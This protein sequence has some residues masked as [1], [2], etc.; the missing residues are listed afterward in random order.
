[1][2]HIARPQGAPAMPAKLAEGEGAFAAQVV[3]HLQPATQ[4][5][6]TA[7]PGAG[8]GAQA[9]DRPGL[10]QQ[11][12]VHWHGSIIQPQ[13]DFSTGHCDHRRAIEAQQRP[14]HGDFQRRSPLVVAQ[15]AIAQ[16]Q[17][18]AVHRP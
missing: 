1:M 16:A 14:A 15:Q 12:G 17:R 6:V 4:A 8:E 13:R 2:Q 9:Q 10:N 7:C 18:A 3:R 5:Q 11:R